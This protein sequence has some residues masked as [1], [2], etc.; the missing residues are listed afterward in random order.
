MVQNN[1]GFKFK[2]EQFADIEIL[3]YRVPGFSELTLKQKELAYCLY[4]AALYGREIIFD[5]HFKHNL[6]IKKTLESILKNYS[7]DRENA[8]FK[9]FLIYIKRFWF[10]NGIHHHYSS[11][12]ILPGFA[13]DYFKLILNGLDEAVKVVVPNVEQLWNPL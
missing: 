8:E 5:Q 7:G 6:T 9:E 3:R 10:S 1:D 4:E 13:E 2:S 11:K 12:K